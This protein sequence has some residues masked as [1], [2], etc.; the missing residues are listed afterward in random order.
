M[1]CPRL[2]EYSPVV[3]WQDLKPVF[4]FFY[5]DTD[6]NKC[7][8]SPCNIIG[9]LFCVYVR[10]ICNSERKWKKKADFISQ[11][12]LNVFI[13]L[14]SVMEAEMPCRATTGEEFKWLQAWLLLLLLLGVSECLIHA[15]TLNITCTDIQMCTHQPG[16][17]TVR[18]L[19][20]TNHTQVWQAMKNLFYTHL[21][22]RLIFSYSR[23][24]D[25]QITHLTK[26]HLKYQT[27]WMGAI[28]KAGVT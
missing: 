15:Q 27:S 3:L 5:I 24:R 1:C 17:D 2:L 28:L 22:N 26:S 14:D 11:F 18:L 8:F 21:I 6:S 13:S 16:Y 10:D 12:T 25:H 7:I 4:T 23:S 19:C 20:H 9:L